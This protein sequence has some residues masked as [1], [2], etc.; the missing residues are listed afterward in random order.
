M[1]RFQE[2]LEDIENNDGR[3]IEATVHSDLYDARHPNHS[4]INGWR[5]FTEV[6]EAYEQKEILIFQR[7]RFNWFVLPEFENEFKRHYPDANLK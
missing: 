1:S 2:L 3:W 4:D 6:E 5:W 7:T